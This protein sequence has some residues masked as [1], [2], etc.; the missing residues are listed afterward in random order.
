[1][2]LLTEQKHELNG[3]TLHTIPT[4]KYK[5]N[6]F[7]LKL[8]APLDEKT[9]TMRALLPYVLQSATESF[10]TTTQLRT[11][12][13]E[14]YGATLQVDLT[15]KGDNHDITIRIDIANEKYLK[16]STPLLQKALAL[17]G[18][19][20]LKPA[21]EEGAFLNDAMEKEKRS[22]RQRIQ[23]V[24]DDKMRYANLRLVEEMCKEEPYSLHVNGRIDDIESITADKLYNYYQHVLKEDAIH[25]YVIGDFHEQEVKNT[26]E[27]AFN[28]PQRQP[29]KIERSITKKEITNVNEVIEKQEVKQGK[30]NIGYRT[31]VVYGDRQYFALQV[32]NGIFGGFSHSKLFINVREKA[33]LAYYAASRV[34]SHKGLLMVMSGIDAKNYDQAITIIKEQ[35]EEMKNGSFTDSEIAQTKAV[36]HNQL[37]ETVDTPRG[38]VEVMYHNELTGKSISVD[39]YL[40]QIDA[41]SKQEIVKVAENIAMDTVYFL[42]GK[43]GENNGEN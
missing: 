9:V 1:M 10:P 12:L 38:L 11:Y 4:T 16:D 29:K 40:K 13:D 17:L 23:A 27:Q 31:N 26:V 15:K 24:F 36:I 42:T 5:T 43:G 19:I 41:V 3:L 28:L 34:E 30:L 8:N 32:F 14:L 7:I 18:E 21:T 37:L 35:M 25:L 6:T 22:L 20:L 33:S 2:K 39:E